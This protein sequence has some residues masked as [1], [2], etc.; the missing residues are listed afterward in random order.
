MFFCIL[1]FSDSELF[2]QNNFN[3]SLF[4]SFDWPL[5]K[6]LSILK[7]GWSYET[8]FGTETTV[9][10]VLLFQGELLGYGEFSPWEVIWHTFVFACHSFADRRDMYLKGF[11]QY[12]TPISCFSKLGMYV[13]MEWFYYLFSFLNYLIQLITWLVCH[14]YANN[15]VDLLKMWGFTSMNIYNKII[16]FLDFQKK[17]N[18]CFTFRRLVKHAY[19]IQT[20]KLPIQLW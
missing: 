15:A 12:Y 16:I 11:G 2:W 18:F 13:F 14:H 8:G 3:Q 7:T 20:V 1:G 19:H 5:L 6:E 9:L 4:L 17:D 10:H